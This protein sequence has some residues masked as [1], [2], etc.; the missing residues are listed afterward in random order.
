MKLLEQIVI[1]KIAT[2]WEMVARYLGY[3]VESIKQI[4]EN[5]TSDTDCCIALFEDWL[6]TNNGTSPKTWSTL[7]K[8][9]KEI[10]PLM[11]ATEKIIQDL[12]KAGILV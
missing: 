12:A 5:V 7:T 1:P 2:D 6:S 9:L 11:S 8:V 10:K 4:K 3:K